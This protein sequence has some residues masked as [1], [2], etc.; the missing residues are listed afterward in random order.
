MNYDKPLLKRFVSYYRPHLALFYTDLAAALILAAIELV[1]PAA[2]TRIIDKL[3]PNGM[4][5]ELIITMAILLGLYI[6]MA[7]M[8]YFMNYWGHVVGVR[9]EADMRSDFFK[10]LQKMPFSFFDKMRTG[11]L[12]SRIVNDLNQV[13]ELAH[14][15]PEDIFIS[16]IMFVGS[17]VVLVQRE[18]RLTLIIYLGVIPFMVWFSIT[19]RKRMSQA[20]RRVREKT[21][22]INAQ[23]ENAL[24]GIRVSQSFTNENYEINRFNEG[25][26][27]FKSAKKEAYHRMASFVTGINFLM[28]VLNVVVLGFGGFFTI[29]G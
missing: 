1:Y 9:M 11:K 22:D 8:N 2:T 12:M 18:W 26:S 3:I 16:V 7:C 20:F 6:I 29:K 10:H 14:H 5:K 13:T 28:T 24:A 27:H 4:V 25:N 21:A 23:L 15:G 19:Q 17:F